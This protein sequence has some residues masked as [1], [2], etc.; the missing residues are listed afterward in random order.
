MSDRVF[1][2]HP[3]KGFVV[4]VVLYGFETIKLHELSRYKNIHNIDYQT[5]RQI[6]NT[7][8]QLVFFHFLLYL[9]PLLSI[10][11]CFNTCIFRYS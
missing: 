11:K 1:I 10:S 3:G 7:V 8:P 9:Y 5:D 6:N 2:P 4:L